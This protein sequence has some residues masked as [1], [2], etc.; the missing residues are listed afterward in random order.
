VT[1][2]VYWGTSVHQ[3]MVHE[4][5]ASTAEA[6]AELHAERR[7]NIRIVDEQGERLTIFDLRALAVMEVDG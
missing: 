1:F 2:V 4:T 6:V 3:F 7:S 5:A